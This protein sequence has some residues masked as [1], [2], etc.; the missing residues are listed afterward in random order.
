LRALRFVTLVP[1]VLAVA[2]ILRIG[3]PALDAKLS[4]RPLAAE[5][6]RMENRPIPL[7]VFKAPRE[8]EYGL[9]FYQNQVIARY[10][11]GQVPSTEHIVVA[12][13]GS[14]TEVAKRVVGR[15]VSYLGTLVA[16]NL[17]YYWVSADLPRRH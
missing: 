10:E 13:S 9:A 14:Q 17:D 15:R 12:P 4:A 8:T 6:K 11:L 5:I 7:A 1:V 3:A 16:Q 2:A